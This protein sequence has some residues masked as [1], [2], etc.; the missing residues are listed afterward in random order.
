MNWP[1]IITLILGFGILVLFYVALRTDTPRTKQTTWV[2]CPGCK[3]ELVGGTQRQVLDTDV[4]RYYCMRCLTVSVWEFDA[5][6][7]LLLDSYYLDPN[8]WPVND[9]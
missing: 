6:V 1:A 5:P 9:E 3:Q 7:P 8:D 2:Y 4:V